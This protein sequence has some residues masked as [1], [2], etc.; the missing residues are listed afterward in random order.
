MK[1]LAT[2]VAVKKQV[3][4]GMARG[5]ADENEPKQAFLL[6]MWVAP[7]ARGRGVGEA[8]IQAVAHWARAAGHSR[9]LL[10]VADVNQPAVDLYER[11]GFEPTGATGSLPSPRE[12][13]REHRRAL[14]LSGC[15][16]EV[17]RETQPVQLARDTGTCTRANRSSARQSA[18][19]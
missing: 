14:D 7:D 4:V 12:H 9:L 16:R 13:I 18:T 3:D 19:R 10:D 5:I 6:S 8:L 2:F 1:R 17:V 11:M 15:C